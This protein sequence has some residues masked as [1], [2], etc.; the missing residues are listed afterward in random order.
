MKMRA[1]MLAVKDTNHDTEEAAQLGHD[2]FIIAPLQPNGPSPNGFGVDTKKPGQIIC[3]G[4]KKSGFLAPRLRS[5][6]GMTSQVE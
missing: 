4:G 3:P 1:A 2:G 5:G 6:L